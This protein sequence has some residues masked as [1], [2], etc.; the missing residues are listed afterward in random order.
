MSFQPTFVNYCGFVL[1]LEADSS[2]RDQ[3]DRSARA[4]MPIISLR[5]EHRDLHPRASADG[6]RLKWCFYCEGGR[7]QT[8][9]TETVWPSGSGN[10]PANANVSRTLGAGD[11]E[12]AELPF[13]GFERQTTF[14]FHS[15]S[16]NKSQSDA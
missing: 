13:R 3:L 9:P 1:I 10:V 16:V 11:P 7:S 5:Q 15:K 4:L 8:H 6:G 12:G 14:I 2:T